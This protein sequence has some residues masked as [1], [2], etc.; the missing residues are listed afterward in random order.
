MTAVIASAL[1][2][3]R[4]LTP[5]AAIAEL[6]D[7]VAPA[8]QEILKATRAVRNQLGTSRTAATLIERFRGE[9]AELGRADIATERPTDAR[10]TP[11]LLQVN[12]PASAAAL[13]RA[14]AILGAVNRM[15]SGL[16]VPATGSDPTAPGQAETQAAYLQRTTLTAPSATGPA[17]AAAAAEAPA[18]APARPARPAR[19]PGP[20]F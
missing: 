15:P 19:D 20:G 16:V 1:R 17:S 10:G 14:Q 12:A 5:D 8:R 4:L 7:A 3:A 9:L 6:R 11:S 18:A 13:D 2:P